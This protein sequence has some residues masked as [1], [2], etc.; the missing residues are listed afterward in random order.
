MVLLDMVCVIGLKLWSFDELHVMD[1]GN[2]HDEYLATTLS[3][4]DKSDSSSSMLLF[5]AG[6]FVGSGSYF[7]ALQR[8]WI[9]ENK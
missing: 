6:S 5:R 1:E 2:G 3:S 7:F 9:I 8:A 4:P